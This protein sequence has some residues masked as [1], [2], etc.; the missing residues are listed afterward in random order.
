MNNDRI[1]GALELWEKLLENDLWRFKL[2]RAW[3][4]AGDHANAANHLR[5]LCHKKADWTVEHVF[6]GRCLLAPARI[7]REGCE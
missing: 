3:F 7:V 4:D 5:T 6:P 1:A 2:T